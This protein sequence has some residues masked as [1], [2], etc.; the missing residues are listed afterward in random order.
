MELI[1]S[2]SVRGGGTIDIRNRRGD[3]RTGCQVSN[4]WSLCID[5]DV[6]RIA[7]ESDMASECNWRGIG[8]VSRLLKARH[9]ASILRPPDFSAVVE[10]RGRDLKDY[11]R[12]GWCGSSS[13]QLLGRITDHVA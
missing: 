10:K 6:R 11:L 7:V 1:A 3:R 4:I 8:E 13:G 9:G 5:V 2:T 12:E